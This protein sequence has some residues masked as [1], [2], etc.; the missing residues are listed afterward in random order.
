MKIVGVFIAALF[1]YIPSTSSLIKKA[2]QRNSQLS[3]TKEVTLS[4]YFGEAGQ[5]TKS[6][7]LT[8][9]FPLNCKLEAEGG[10][11]LSVK[12]AASEG[13]TGP[14][15]QLLQ[16]ACPLLATRSLSLNEAAGTLRTAATSAGVDLTAATSLARI[17][18]R[19]A[20]VL[21]AAAHDTSRPQLWLYK[22]SRA[23]ARLIAQSGADLRL[24]QY[25]DP[26]AGDWF[27]RVIE[28]YNGGQL[29]ARFET[30]DAK[31]VR[32]AGEDE[33]DDSRE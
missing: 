28:L 10:P 4:G 11:T 26:A 33:D 6:A 19:T 2:A 31:G 12:G 20:Y 13:T 16:M 23:P 1:A 3:K 29:A 9:H 30:L 8:L 14:A 7:T 32:Q 22:D 15:L 5:A 25:G 27:P 18:D 17:G 21:G 24:L